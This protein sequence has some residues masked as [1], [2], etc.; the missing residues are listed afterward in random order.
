ML[1]GSNGNCKVRQGSESDKQSPSNRQPRYSLTRDWVRSNLTYRNDSEN[2][3]WLSN[4]S[5]GSYSQGDSASDPETNQDP[6]DSWL[7]F[8]LRTPKHTTISRNKV[9]KRIH[10]SLGQSTNFKAWHRALRSD[11]TL[12]QQDFD[13]VFRHNRRSKSPSS[14]VLAAMMS[15][16]VPRREP[17]TPEKPLPPAPLNRTVSEAPVPTTSIG[18]AEP[19]TS[20]KRPSVS[21]TFS[22][23]RP[24]KKL[25]WKGKA[26][27]I[28]LPLEDGKDEDGGP[29][30]PL[31]QDE[32][33]DRLERWKQQGFD[34][35]GFDLSGVST[36]DPTDRGQSRD[37]FPDPREWHQDW[38]SKNFRVSIPDQMAW[39]SYV[40]QLQE[41]KLRALGVSF[42]D[43][44]PVTK[45][46]ILPSMS[47]QPSSQ[48]SITASMPGAP[49]SANSFRGQLEKTFSPSLPGSTSHFS[50]SQPTI[51]PNLQQG[52]RTGGFHFPKQSMA[53]PGDSSFPSGS[54]FPSQPTPPLSGLWPQAQHLASLPGSRGVSPL[55]DGRRQS[56]RAT[57]SPLSPLPDP[58]AESY[59][60]PQ[61]SLPHHLRQQQNQ[62][63]PAMLP[64][65]QVQNN[66]QPHQ[67]LH[68]I[69]NN[70]ANG[71]DPQPVR[72]LSQ[73]EIASPLPQG[74][75]HNLS[76]TLQ[77]E[78][79]EA[80]YHLEES[81]RRQL[82]DDDD[83]ALPHLEA[84]EVPEE[85]TSP[86]SKDHIAEPRK[87][88]KA[89][90]SDIETNPSVPSSPRPAILKLDSSVSARDHPGH[91]PKSSAS[92]LNVNAQEFVFDPTKT[93]FT[94]MFSFGSRSSPSVGPP[95]VSA[96]PGPLGLHSKNTSN[97]STFNSNLNVTAPAFTP[98]KFQGP[99]TGNQ[100]FS[101]SSS[102]PAL[103]S[104]AP[105]F[106]PG[107][108]TAPKVDD[109]PDEANTAPPRIFG[110]FNYSDIIK[111]AKRSKAIPIVKPNLESDEARYSDGQEDESG[112]IT[113][114]DGRQ[115]RQRR[116]GDSG[117]QIPLFASP[118]PSPTP[119]K[120]IE[121]IRRPSFVDETAPSV[122]T[123]LDDDTTPTEKA[124][125]RL[126]EIVDELPPS[127]APSSPEEVELPSATPGRFRLTDDEIVPV[128][129]ESRSSS[130]SVSSITAE[131]P[132]ENKDDLNDTIPEQN[133]DLVTNGV[134]TLASQSTLSA[135]AKPFTFKPTATT[136]EPATSG[137]KPIGEQGH[138]PTSGSRQPSLQAGLG[139]SR[140]APRES[141]PQ[142]SPQ[143][144]PRPSPVLKSNLPE[145]SISPQPLDT[146]IINGVHYVEPTTYQEIDDV[147]RRL[148][149]D[150]SDVGVERN[151]IKTWKSP[152][153]SVRSLRAG[154]PVISQDAREYVSDVDDTEHLHTKRQ[155][156]TASPNRLQQPF[157]YLPEQEFG[158]SDSAKARLVAK[159]ARFS[160]SYKPSKHPFA[161]VRSPVYNLNN[162]DHGIISDWDD[163][164]SSGE[165]AKFHERSR[166]FANRVDDVVSRA[167]KDR[168]RPL[169]QAVADVSASLGRIA[170]R[171]RSRR[172]RRSASAEI[173]NS[174]ADDED[175]ETTE[176]RALSPLRDRKYDKLKS[177]LIES[178][179]AQK[180]T[181]PSYELAKLTGSLA[182]VKTLL[183]ERQHLPSTDRPKTPNEF[184]TVVE[185]ITELRESLQK[186]QQASLDPTSPK[187]ENVAHLTKEIAELRASLEEQQKRPNI[188]SDVKAIIEDAISK[189]TRGKSAPVTSSQEA[190]AAEKLRLQVTG[191]ESMLKVA[192]SRADDEF[193]ARRTVENELAE[194][195]RML[196]AAEAEASEQ[197]ESAEETELSLRSF[198]DDQQQSKQHMAMLE[199]VKVALE[200]TISDLSEKN[201]ALEDTLEEYR[202][203]HTEWRSEMDNANRENEDLDRTI[204]A[205]KSELEDGINTKHAFKDK[206][207]RLQEDMAETARTVARD[208][209]S[210]RN[211]EEE[212]KIKHEHLS[213]RLEAEARTRERLELEIDRLEKQEK[214][215]MKS[216]FLVDQIRAEN[217]HLVST[218]NDLRT[219]SHQYQD[220]AMDLERQL[221]DAKE[222]NRLEIQRI[223]NS[224][225]A[226]VGA[227]NQQVEIL[228]QSLEG[229]IGRLESQL[230][231]A[232]TDASSAKQRYEMMLEEASVSRDVALREAAEA[233]EAALQE[234][235]RFHERTLEE[236]KASHTRALKE[237]ESSH[238]RALTNALDDHQRAMSNVVDD[239]ERALNTAMED[240]RMTESDLNRRLNFADEKISHYQERTKSLEE[241]VEIA[242]SAAQAAA[243]AARSARSST[244]IPASRGSMPVAPGSDLPEK[245]SPQALRE[246]ILVL[247]EQL[248]ERESQIERLEQELAKV[249]RDAPNKVRDRD[250]EISWLRELLGV[251][252]DDLQEI[253]ATLE[254]P[255]YD[256]DEVR[257]AAIRLK[258]NLQ[259]EQQEKERAMA[260]GQGFPSLASLSSITASPRSL[261]MAA[262][263]A[264]GNW[265][266]GQSS[267]G[268]LVEMAAP[269]ASASQT[270]PKS[271]PQS[272]LSGLL[273]PPNTNIRQTPQP[274]GSSSARQVRTA[275]RPESRYPNSKLRISPSRE[276][277]RQASADL[278]EPPQTP[279]LLRTASY[280]RDAESAHYSLDRYVA[281]D[282]ENASLED[283]HVQAEPEPEGIF[284]PG[285]ELAG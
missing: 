235:Y 246:S 258:A 68:R 252:L 208:Q 97:T 171:S 174:D 226:D 190:A 33:A 192:E 172:Y 8:K 40:K 20:N 264:F 261:P 58:V 165:E 249:D 154:S 203:S 50:H 71:G 75:K 89:S 3:N 52:P 23:Q 269:S 43:E 140:Y 51:S 118:T 186:Q 237:L 179:N 152:A 233:R 136:F 257:D 35:Q 213:A 158:S 28:A 98:G 104:N 82:E 30:Q 170:S 54:Q 194:S 67:N 228:R 279:P 133:K 272:F 42:G 80:E 44:E 245:I 135:T 142:L 130:P 73:P 278:V 168:L 193:R 244:T 88:A 173:E 163:V 243:E 7:N 124:T 1:K 9:G 196:K 37:I 254:S 262:A 39:E 95:S 160:P 225:K 103:N 271:S 187:V 255:S 128:A 219:K 200:K 12:T 94:P 45:S 84:E 184:T 134:S 157:Q 266:K 202:K 218:V 62:F 48:A 248:H 247:Q 65:L 204:Q 79:D 175:D 119:E 56:L 106:T 205:L 38:Q 153:R 217:N 176:V 143:L 83:E 238:N 87:E 256:R 198:L 93:S 15:G 239:H 276:Q 155:V 102:V 60:N 189:Q 141:S 241:R 177:L 209:A 139:A 59:F 107:A 100:E 222:N 260:G 251:R 78:I 122:V 231:H 29:K 161:D 227:A 224:T 206:F 125:D 111:P 138:S 16:A 63:H 55:M 49:L 182:E 123:S 169:E 117:N 126:K 5:D 230:E 110:N 108:G 197:R 85:K 41:E 146:R 127:D 121:P 164:V 159:N 113:Q 232:K 195:R 31:K 156:I 129:D 148:N 216:R 18:P 185:A 277:S 283:G 178:M 253:I 234:H 263:A 81:I 149:G 19:S 282:D 99:N 240:K 223:L 22:F 285:I 220:K 268:S 69:L 207:E 32:V 191:L 53:F 27:V 259:M 120:P 214:E 24:K 116:S 11:A 4:G 132:V 34:V 267:L 147:M 74:H 145:R 221:H 46:P 14:D 236:T 36:N 112:R 96:L 137:K 242:R 17:S 183:A 86:G 188:V 201:L 215:A 274:R 275:R 105:S 90:T 76:A 101:F 131:R 64:Q 229:V 25:M 210:W 66:L 151:P 167:V 47:R 77:K 21:S 273:T 181:A 212:H 91:T 109:R 144:S 92:R 10:G 61:G 180:T 284:G 150:D 281:K 250:V 2:R 72:Y 70:D 115:K 114:A 211:K 13:D 199:E 162:A 26:C 280:D 57:H 270:P 166:F 265:R 6:S